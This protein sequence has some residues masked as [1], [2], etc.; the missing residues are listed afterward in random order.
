MLEKQLFQPIKELFESDGFMVDGEVRKIDML[1]M[2][3]DVSVAVELKKELNLKVI[4]QAALRQ[5]TID[6]VYVGIFSPKSLHNK[7]F[8]EKLYLLKR[9]GIGLIIVA[10]R[11]LEA[12]V[13]QDPLVSEV[14]DYRTPQQKEKGTD[15]QRNA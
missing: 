8:K 9:L 4:I 13:Y 2:K 12:S 6:I 15:N 5:K 1:C 11:S 10:P 7:R 14:P 3:D